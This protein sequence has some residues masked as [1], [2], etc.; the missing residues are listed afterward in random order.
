MKLKLYIILFSI[1]IA[2][3]GA[4]SADRNWSGCVVDVYYIDWHSTSRS[5]LSEHD[6]RTFYDIKSTYKRRWSVKRIRQ[7]MQLDKLVKTKNVEPH[8]DLRLVVDFKCIDGHMETFVA[9][10]FRLKNL[11]G[12]YSR[13][14]DDTF[15]INFS[16]KYEF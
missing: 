8:G 5:R 6:V 16:A 7:I 13:E 12:N 9:D 15:K 11:K 2:S 10:N 3:L 14:I 1:A 4:K